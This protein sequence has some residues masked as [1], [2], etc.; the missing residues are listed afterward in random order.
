MK[1]ALF[2]A[3]STLAAG[4][5]LAQS[6]VT[7]YGRLNETV[8]R[9]KVA[10]NSR[11]VV[12]DNA[13]RL[14]FKGS[15]DLGGGLKANFLLE[16]RFRPD[17]GTA[18]GD[19]WAGDSWVGL[20]SSNY[21][22]LRLGR[23]ISTAYFATADY[24]SY[25][26]HDTGSSSDALY[27]LGFQ[28]WYTKNK[29]AYKTPSLA[30]ATVE[31]QYGLRETGVAPA[32]DRNSNGFELA[33]NYNVGDLALG[34]GFT[35]DGADKQVAVRG[36]YTIGAFT[37]GGY[38]QRTGFKD[39]YATGG[40]ANI[41]RLAGMYTLGASEF[42]ANAGLAG[43]RDGI[44]DSDAQ[45]FTLGYNYNLSKRTKVYTYFTK[46]NAEAATAY[47]ADYSSLALGIRHNF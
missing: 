12:N 40:K 29:I 46:I 34:L 24:V 25:H 43:K 7:I 5:A 3:L 36:Q 45:Q 2:I 32:S 28:S 9:E 20:S 27:N 15:E 44:A 47:V 35:K 38:Y 10:G 19:F 18:A 8:E 33:A 31:V 14:G 42:H 13:S 11:T 16:H 1:R 26:N 21:G 41:F 30:G 6:N 4:S 37:L 39:I 17:T 22:A 23:M